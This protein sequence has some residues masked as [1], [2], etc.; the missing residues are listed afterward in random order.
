MVKTIS[1]IGDAPGLVFDADMLERTGLKAGD[2][3]SV[4][5][6]P[7]GAIA[8]VPVRPIVPADV[9]EGTPPKGVTPWS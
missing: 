7:D 9:A 8:L 1:T 2:P 3:V 6:L 4:S 5:I